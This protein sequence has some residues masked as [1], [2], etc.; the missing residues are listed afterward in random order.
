MNYGNRVGVALL[1]VFVTACASASS[2]PTSPPPVSMCPT[3]NTLTGTSELVSTQISNGPTVLL[4][5]GPPQIRS[6]KILNATH[7]SVITRQ[8]DT[9]LRAGAGRYTLT[10]T[11]YTETVELA[12]SAHFVP[13][14]AYSFRITLQDDT[15]TI[16]GG[17]GSQQLPEVWR[18]VK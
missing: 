16:E 14:Q 15:W 13:G 2:I 18:R 4:E 10:G 1:A 8:G 9:F 3:D 17:S 5:G 6:L 7:Y 11:E 12:S